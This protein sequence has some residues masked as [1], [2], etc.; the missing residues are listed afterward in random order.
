MLFTPRFVAK[1]CPA[2]VTYVTPAFP[3]VLSGMLRSLKKQMSRDGLRPAGEALQGTG[4]EHPLPV[5]S[6]DFDFSHRQTLP[7]APHRDAWALEWLSTYPFSH[8][9]F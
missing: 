5:P 3:A 9:F 7:P 8:P 2:L 1:T 6:E 4:N